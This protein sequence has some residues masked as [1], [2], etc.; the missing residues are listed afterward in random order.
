MTGSVL[1]H[2][3]LRFAAH[4]ENIATEA[5]CYLLNGSASCRVGLARFL[6]KLGWTQELR[7]FE[8]QAASPNGPRPDLAA[9]TDDGQVRVLIEAKFWAGLTEYQ[10]VQYLR[11]GFTASAGDLSPGEP[12][13]SLPAGPRLLLFVAPAQ[14]MATLQTELAQR[15]REKQLQVDEVTTTG[16]VFRMQV[17]GATLALCSWRD[18]LDAF[19]SSCVEGHDQTAAQ[20]LAQ[21]QALCEYM[22]ETAFLPLRAEDLNPQIGRRVLQFGSLV[23]DLVTELTKTDRGDRKG[24]RPGGSNGYYGRYMRFDGWGLIVMFEASLWQSTGESPLW[25]GYKEI[26]GDSWL[27]SETAF[28][29]C[30]LAGLPVHDWAGFCTLPLRLNTGVERD[31]VLRSLD[32][33]VKAYADLLGAASEN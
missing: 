6:A 13:P 4:P 14:R 22:D 5:L 24:L 17:L 12:S 21:L 10:P 23:D 15:V 33:Q 20:D 18:L 16:S 29:R 27:R 3:A 31:E 19:E 32:A 9:R 8:S 7:T 1:S 28:H 30:R 2:L 11:H 26:Q 25:V